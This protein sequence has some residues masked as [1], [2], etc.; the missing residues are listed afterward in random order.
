M[1]MVTACSRRTVLTAVLLTAL[2]GKSAGAQT[3]AGTPD[4]RP[5]SGWT[6]TDASGVPLTLDARPLRIVAEV[7]VAAG[8]WDYGVVPVGVFGELVNAAGEPVPSA[9][10]IDVDAVV[11]TWTGTWGEPDLE[12]IVALQ[13]DVIIGPT[14]EPDRPGW[15]DGL[16]DDAAAV[17]MDVAP[18]LVIDISGPL[19]DQFAQLEALAGA[20]GADL[21]TPAVAAAHDAFAQAVEAFQSVTA[22]KPDLTVLFLS[23]T[24]DQAYIAQQG[25]WNDIAYY[26]SLGL[27]PAGPDGTEGWE[28]VSWERIGEFPSDVILVDSRNDAFGF[29]IEDLRALPT[30]KTLPAVQADQVGTWYVEFVRSYA[31]FV[32]ALQHMTE[33]LAAAEVVTGSATS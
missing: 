14:Y 28:E 9:G 30:V 20:L 11:D 5:A 18:F 17:L 22:A 12:A 10:A 13:P 2:A 26:A 8:L 6:F 21:E 29:G 1:A 15:L 7:S 4:S 24:A 23:A 32:P 33:V 25:Y 19:P 16:S 31:G 3:P 27:N